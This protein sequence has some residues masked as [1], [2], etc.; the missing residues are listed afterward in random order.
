MLQKETDKH[1]MGFAG[2]AFFSAKELRDP[3]PALSV[4]PLHR[5]GPRRQQ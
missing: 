2:E 3:G 5:S 4:G 1:D